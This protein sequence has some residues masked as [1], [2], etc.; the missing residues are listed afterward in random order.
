[1]TATPY[2]RQFN[3]TS[4]EASNP[5]KPKPGAS[6]DAE[7]NA[8][9]TAL[10]ST[11]SGLAQ[12]QRDDGALANGCVTF[13]S[14]DEDLQSAISAVQGDVSAVSE[15]RDAAQAAAASAATSS[16]D[17]QAYM[18]S[19]LANASAAVVHATNAANSAILAQ[20]QATAA[21]ASADAAAA[22]LAAMQAPGGVS[23][24]MLADGAVNYAKVANGMTVDHAYAE[25]TLN[26]NLTTIMPADDTIPQITEGTQILSATITPKSTTNR[27]RIRVNSAFCSS[28]AGVNITAAVFRSGVANALCARVISADGAGP[29][30]HTPLTLEFEHVPGVTSAVTYSVRVGPHIAAT[31]RA[32][33]GTTS[34]Q[35]GGVSRSTLSIE[36]IKA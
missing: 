19:S 23:T 16:T 24:A 33:G 7:F 15:A 6:L 36:E 9:K 13:D 20:D 26:E 8:V 1:M 31:L 32:N 21:D 11:Q 35:L 12:I 22:T 4:F 18:S 17:A 2:E 29:N 3:F 30:Y 34:R 10:D 28:V 14:L 5:S 25:Y 27:I